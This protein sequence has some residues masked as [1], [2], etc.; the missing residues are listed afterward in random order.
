[1]IAF[2]YRIFSKGHR[3]NTKIEIKIWTKRNSLEMRFTNDDFKATSP[4]K[5]R[6]RCTSMRNISEY[7][8]GRS[9]D[10]WGVAYCLL[11]SSS[12]INGCI[13]INQQW[14]T[15]RN[16]AKNSC[17]RIYVNELLTVKLE[18][19]SS[20]YYFNL[21]V[22]EVGIFN[23]IDRVDFTHNWL[24]ELFYPNLKNRV[25]WNSLLWPMT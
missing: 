22:R 17:I 14:Y 24:I 1:M 8:E 19:L 25:I 3:L 16:T 4:S 15:P 13:K 20:C 11:K 6:D 21:I 12:E 18:L 7:K 23:M 9:G 2:I 10:R 5:N